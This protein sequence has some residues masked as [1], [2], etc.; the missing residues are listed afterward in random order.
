MEQ[1]LILCI[2]NQ[3]NLNTNNIVDDLSANISDIKIIHPD[4]IYNTPN[5]ERDGEQRMLLLDMGYKALYTDRVFPD[6]SYIFARN[7]NLIST[8]PLSLTTCHG[9]KPGMITICMDNEAISFV[10]WFGRGNHVYMYLDDVGDY[11]S[12]LRILMMLVDRIPDQY[13]RQSGC[14][15]L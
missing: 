13:V 3:T 14:V 5:I 7:V 12:V 4:K 10:L 8:R 9:Y 1:K 11:W 6:T 2:N 15:I